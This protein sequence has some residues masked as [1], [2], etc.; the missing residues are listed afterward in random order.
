MVFVALLLSNLISSAA[1]AP[2]ADLFSSPGKT[3]PACEWRPFDAEPVVKPAYVGF[4]TFRI[5]GS[6][7]GIDGSVEGISVIHPPTCRRLKFGIA[8]R[9]ASPKQTFAIFFVAGN[10]KD[11]TALH[12]TAEWEISGDLHQD[13][14]TQAEREITLPAETQ[15]L[16]IVIHNPNKGAIYLSALHLLPG[17]AAEPDVKAIA[18]A[19]KDNAL[20]EEERLHPSKPAASPF[21]KVIDG[22]ASRPGASVAHILMRAPLCTKKSGQTG[23]VTFPVPTIAVGQV[24]LAYK[25][26]C[27]APG[28]LIG[29]SWRNRSD[30]RNMVCDVTVKPGTK[31]A[32]VQYEALVLL[33][34]SNQ[35]DTAPP[36]ASSWK[37]STAC[38]QSSAPQI[39][40]IEQKLAKPGD[41]TESYA[42]KVMAF[43][44]D[45]G[46]KGAPFIALDAL[47]AL[48]C[49]GSCTNKAN[50]SAA[51][52][53]AHGIPA[54]TVSHMPVWASDK[55]YEHWLTEYWQPEKGWVA[56]DSTIGSW[57]PDRRSRV[58]LSIANPS[59]ED[60]AFEPLHERF[61][62][63]GAPYLSVAELTPTLYPADLTQDDAINS[64]DE[65][66][67][68][69]VSSPAESAVFKAATK[70][71]KAWFTQRSCAATDAERYQ[72]VLAASRSG[73]ANA[74]LAAIKFGPGGK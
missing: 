7:Y 48:Q 29:Y 69:A 67:R 10:P 14:W 60:L 71:F 4:Q 62:M 68:L 51:L 72:N 32:W 65:I 38:V 34:S 9:G 53:R 1:Q 21:L 63:P 57:E 43:V 70:S 40:A 28:T 19:E 31:G 58:V 59:D 61:V 49:G 30:G 16:R 44:R 54:R 6:S 24:P 35:R 17:E 37:Q 18:A 11:K 27:Q 66:G 13:S 26:V 22:I 52:L 36:T 42:R 23:V 50:L 2:A 12:W 15:Y 8:L 3:T 39:Q 33:G 74:L 47:A 41:T 5:A 64:V 46:G 25:V 73:K 56:I 55:F 20:Y 45:D